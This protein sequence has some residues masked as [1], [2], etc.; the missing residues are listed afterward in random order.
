[1]GAGVSWAIN[2]QTSGICHIF[3]KILKHMLST[4]LP[5]LS[6]YVLPRWDM[7]ASRLAVAAWFQSCGYQLIQKC[8]HIVLSFIV[9]VIP[10]QFLLAR[11]LPE[12]DYT[13]TECAQ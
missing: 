10:K 3:H 8:K 13:L 2:K 9:Y 11:Y 1:M 6:E 5:L 4:C 7:L 12:S